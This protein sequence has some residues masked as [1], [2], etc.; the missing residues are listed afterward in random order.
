[1][2]YLRIK[3]SHV[4][5]WERHKRWKTCQR[6]PL[7]ETRTKVCLA[8]GSFP[9]PLALIGEAPGLSEDVDGYP[10]TGEAGY[11]LNDLI[12]E[13]IP[14]RLKYLIA[15]VVGCLPSDEETNQRPPNKEE[16]RACNQRLRELLWMS[17]PKI[18]VAMGRV[19]KSHI[20]K[21]ES[22]KILQMDHPS[23]IQRLSGRRYDLAYALAL[24]VLKEAASLTLEAI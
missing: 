11:L 13:A 2:T 16:C 18:V 5:K 21:S 22:F 14:K 3:P 20:P 4:K 19:A 15:N 24:D 23:S 8:R 10:F 7:S 12:A 1:M 6:C 17:K 9:A